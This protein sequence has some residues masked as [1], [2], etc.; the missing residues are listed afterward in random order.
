MILLLAALL[1]ILAQR[2]GLCMVKSVQRLRTR[3]PGLLIVILGCGVWFWLATPVFTDTPW[4]KGITRY[5]STW[6][7]ALG[8]GLFGI[9][10]AFNQGCTLSTLTALS[11]GHYHMLATMAG[12]VLGWWWLGWLSPVIEYQSLGGAH[13][14]PWWLIG[15][16]AVGSVLIIWRLAP[17]HRRI[18]AGVMVFGATAGVLGIMEPS[19]SPSQLIEQ[20]ST[21]VLT[22]R[23]PWPDMQ[24][25]LISIALVAG[26]ILAATP[27]VSWRQ[28][29]SGPTRWAK[30][31]LAGSVMGVGSA[32]ALGGNDSQLLLALPSGSPAAAL[33]LASMIAGIWLGLAIEQ[34][35]LCR[36]KAL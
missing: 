9:A 2:T 26:M 6:P 5:A 35:Y 10:A 32:L 15:I 30:H 16:A 3:Q 34:R 29:Q 25:V 12:W 27:R 23:L 1:G 22:G 14:P 28:Y 17:S 20:V 8:G 19:W 11:R 31:L 7:F 4:S 18:Y 13:P 24:R 36:K 21:R 33:A